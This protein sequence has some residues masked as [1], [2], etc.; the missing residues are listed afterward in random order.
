MHAGQRARLHVV[1]AER[2][3]LRTRND[4]VGRPR[5][6]EKEQ[7][8]DTGEPRD[9]AVSLELATHAEEQHHE[10]RTDASHGALPE[11][12]QVRSDGRI[13]GARRER[14]AERPR[15]CR[16]RRADHAETEHA[17]A[18][19]QRG[20]QRNGDEQDRADPV[21]H[22]LPAPVQVSHPGT[23]IEIRASRA[24]RSACTGCTRTD[25]RKYR[26]RPGAS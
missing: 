17:I 21:R 18:A 7:S 5:D 4:P 6:D 16:R 22:C 10:A 25:R 1:H 24:E 8:D 9:P 14:L 19:D 23:V 2:H 3:V 12:Q 26:R 15:C 13:V 11:P 20:A